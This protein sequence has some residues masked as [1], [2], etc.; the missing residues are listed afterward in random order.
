MS[1]KNMVRRA[2]YLLTLAVC[3]TGLAL[4]T[5][6]A[7]AAPPAKHANDGAAAA[8]LS[9]G[10][11]GGFEGASRTG[12]HGGTV[13]PSDGKELGWGWMATADKRMGGNSSASVALVHP[14][15]GGTQGALRANGVLKSGF[16][17]PWAG[18]IWFPGNHPMQATDLSG[19]KTLTF[20]VRGKPGSYTL[21]MMVGSTHSIPQSAPFTVTRD[22]QTVTIPLAETFPGAKLKRVY[23]L[24]FS[25]GNYGKFQFELDDVQL[26]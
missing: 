7:M 12:R 17:S 3:G 16:I 5:Q 6:G 8:P 18:A 13:V 23:F 4:S 24:A 2:G 15:A 11:A 9:A 26:H 20:K 19:I 22:W 21:L 25:A 10:L 1:T 14:G